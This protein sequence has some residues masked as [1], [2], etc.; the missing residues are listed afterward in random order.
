MEMAA[1]RKT[2]LSPASF[3]EQMRQYQLPRPIMYRAGFGKPPANSAPLTVSDSEQTVAHIVLVRCGERRSGH[4]S[5]GAMPLSGPLSRAPALIP[6][7]HSL[8]AIA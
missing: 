6:T 5:A 3:T 7:L 1:A 8:T 4:L 2:G